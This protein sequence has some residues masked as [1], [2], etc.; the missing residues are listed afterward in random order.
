MIF[1]KGNGCFLIH[2]DVAR[3]YTKRS[4]WQTGL[5]LPVNFTRIAAR[6]S[7]H[8]NRSTKI[9]MANLTNQVCYFFN[10]WNNAIVI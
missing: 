4:K 6:K 1:N 5:F 7:W 10:L 3:V 2:V 9:K 8:M